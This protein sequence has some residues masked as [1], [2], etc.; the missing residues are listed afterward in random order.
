MLSRC[1]AVRKVVTI[2][3]VVL[4]VLARAGGGAADVDTVFA[5]ARQIFG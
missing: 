2:G 3:K 5:R 4:D 1:L